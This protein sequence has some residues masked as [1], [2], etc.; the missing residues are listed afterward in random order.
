MTACQ[1][2]RPSELKTDNSF[3]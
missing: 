2:E 3:L 1:N